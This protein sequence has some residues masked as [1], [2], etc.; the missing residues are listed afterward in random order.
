LDL[1]VPGTI[2]TEARIP[3]DQTDM[4]ISIAQH[5][6]IYKYSGTD[7]KHDVWKLL[8]KAEGCRTR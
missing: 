1:T 6:A 3:A 8:E 2:V 7:E 4:A 5:E